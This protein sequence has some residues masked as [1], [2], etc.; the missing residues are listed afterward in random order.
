MESWSR[1]W[2]R[3]LLLARLRD[4]DVVCIGAEAGLLQYRDMCEEY[5]RNRYVYVPD[6]VRNKLVEELNARVSDEEF[7]AAFK[8]VKPEILWGEVPFRGKYY[9]YAGNGDLQLKGSWDEVKKD[10][11]EALEK[12]GERLYAFIKAIVELTEEMLEK[13]WPEHCYIFGPDYGSIL[14]RM[15]EILG[16]VVTPLPNDFVLLKAYGL[17]YKSGSRRYPGHSIPLEII[18]AVKEALN[19]WEKNRGVKGLQRYWKPG[20]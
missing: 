8:K 14:R 9:T 13:Y 2:E 5:R 6:D 1:E 4:G 3:R 19:E 11:Y 7:L 17:Y 15:R 18:P 20:W 16:E 12:G 10:A